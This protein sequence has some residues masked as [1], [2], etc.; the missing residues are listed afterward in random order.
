MSE[1]ELLGRV[2]VRLLPEDLKL[3]DV[4]S[5]RPIETLH[6]KLGD[7]FQSESDNLLSDA[8]MQIEFRRMMFEKT[9]NPVYVIETFIISYRNGL[10][11]PIWVLSWLCDHFEDWA[12][13]AGRK[14][15]DKAFELTAGKGQTKPFEK[16]D[17]AWRNDN[18]CLEVW[19]LRH[20]FDISLDDACSMVSA[21]L[22]TPEARNIAK[23]RTNIFQTIK[24]KTTYVQQ[25]ISEKRIRDIVAGRD[26]FAM[27]QLS[28]KEELTRMAMDKKG[29]KKFIAE[30]ALG[31]DTKKDILSMYPSYSVPVGL[32]NIDIQETEQSVK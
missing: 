4:D 9:D 17:I 14:T 15:L 21:R 30:T 16:I 11:P 18:L 2:F 25:N 6:I 3:C 22:Q 20:V 32:Q 12:E 26:P 1:E 19:R 8:R 10:Y 7:S 24:E 29:L 28:T 31:G 27:K 13:N 23:K 5:W